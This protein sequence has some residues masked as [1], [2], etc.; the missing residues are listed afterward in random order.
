MKTRLTSLLPLT[1]LG[2]V[3]VAGE[4]AAA[5]DE[6]VTKSDKAKDEGLLGWIGAVSRVPMPNL[7]GLITPEKMGLL[8]DNQCRIRDNE[9]HLLSDNETEVNVL[10]GNKVSTL[11]GNRLLSGITINVQVTIHGPNAEASK[12]NS[13]D[14]HRGSKKSKRH[15]AARKTKK[16]EPGKAAA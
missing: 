15:K 1:A 10:S 16:R 9:A 4:L 6:P 12:P 11:S 13:G 14:R 2:V 3:L 7:S 8:T 5:G